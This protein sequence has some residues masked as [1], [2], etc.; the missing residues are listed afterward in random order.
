MKFDRNTVTSV[1]WS[2]YPILTFSDVPKI[3][4]ELVDRP[5]EKPVGAAEAACTTVAPAL[6]NAVFDATGA[7]LRILPLTP[8]RVKAA[9]QGRA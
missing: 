2:S 1:D 6:A 7:R 3:E 8:E 4:I 5:N 9:L